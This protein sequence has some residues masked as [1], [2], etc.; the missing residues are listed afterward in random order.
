MFKNSTTEL[1]QHA[2]GMR[3]AVFGRRQA[4]MCVSAWL[5]LASW[6]S[7][8]VGIVGTP[9]PG[10]TSKNA[11]GSYP[12]L[13][14]GTTCGVVLFFHINKCAGGTVVKWLEARAARFSNE[15]S[16]SSTWVGSREMA[17]QEWIEIEKNL[18]RYAHEAAACSPLVQ[19]HSCHSI[20]RACMSPH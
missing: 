1:P 13:K 11:G 15:F 16:H 6:A 5:L 8:S 2:T 18:T 9:S 10:S 12:G 14:P 19:A 4:G 7:C 3:V 20:H 17:N